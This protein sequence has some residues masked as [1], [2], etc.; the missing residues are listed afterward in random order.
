MK[1]LRCGYCCTQYFT[2]I[3]VDPDKYDPDDPDE[4]NLRGIDLSKER[5]PHL[6]GDIPGEYSCAIHHYP[7]FADTPCGMHTQFERS[8][9]PCRIGTQ[10][11]K[12]GKN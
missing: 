6:R 1:C 12:K 10:I 9:S 4:S 3:V 5:C 11:M 7:W 8:D 2:V